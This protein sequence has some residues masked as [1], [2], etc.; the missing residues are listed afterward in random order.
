[1][2]KPEG[3]EPAL[4]AILQNYH[5]A[6]SSKEYDAENDDHDP[7]MDLYG[8]T[9]LLKREN[10]QSWG[11]ELG[12]CWQLIVSRVFR[13]TREDF[14]PAV[15][16]GADEPYDFTFGNIAVDTKYRIGSGDSGTLKKFKQYGFMLREKGF[17]PVFLILRNDN[18]PAAIGACRAGRWD[19]FTGNAALDYVGD[20]TNFDLKAF[21]E[22]RA[23]KF[24]VERK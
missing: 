15:R 10:R 20:H 24:Q 21:L 22:Q 14:G 6:F 23:L 3:L 18:L 2:E 11:R 16:F 8:I 5:R 17:T 4:E 12:M 9:P 19:V 1:M 13:L 7:L